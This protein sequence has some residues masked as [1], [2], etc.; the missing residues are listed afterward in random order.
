VDAGVGGL[1]AAACTTSDARAGAPPPFC[2][3]CV[4]TIAYVPGGAFG[5]VKLNAMAPSDAGVPVHSVGPDVLLKLIWT[6]LPDGLN[7]LPDPLTDV[8][9]V[10]VLCCSEMRA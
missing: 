2:P 8:P 5:T 10:A 6:A 7:P 3:D 9:G 1:V 4:A